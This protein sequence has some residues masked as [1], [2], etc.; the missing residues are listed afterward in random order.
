MSKVNFNPEVKKAVD[1]ILLKNSS[2][3]S[4]KMFGLTVPLSLTIYSEHSIISLQG[5]HCLLHLFE[6]DLHLTLLK[7]VNSFREFTILIIGSYPCSV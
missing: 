2:V 5:Y 6:V 1:S 7:N 4:G 3:V